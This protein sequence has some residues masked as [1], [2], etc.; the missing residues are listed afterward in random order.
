MFSLYIYKKVNSV[1]N[2]TFLIYRCIKFILGQKN[3][4]IESYWVI[5]TWHWPLNNIRKIKQFC[6]YESPYMC[7]TG[8]CWKSS[9]VALPCI[10]LFIN[11]M[12]LQQRLYLDKQTKI[13][14]ISIYFKAE[15]KTL[16]RGFKFVL[17]DLVWKYITSA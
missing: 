15:I 10:F 1:G 13:L 12:L 2:D 7:Q 4:H 16:I 17:F 6:L 5:Q 8:Y 3:I 11:E 14:S 9:F